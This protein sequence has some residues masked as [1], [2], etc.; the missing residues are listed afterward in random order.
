MVIGPALRI[1]YVTI[2]L[3]ITLTLWSPALGAPLYRC[4]SL[5]SAYIYT[6]SP[7]QLER[8][9]PLVSAPQHTTT[10]QGGSSGPSWQ[11]PVQELVPPPPTYLPPAMTSQPK[12]HAMNGLPPGSSGVPIPA[13][14]AAVSSTRLCL[15]GINP[16]NQLSV[17]PC[18]QGESSTTSPETAPMPPR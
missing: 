14:P 6:D 5:E 2:G 7:A 12:S 4:G 18:P 8:C 16:L 1:G 15:V 10:N 11:A 3:V 13:S 9:T 17:P